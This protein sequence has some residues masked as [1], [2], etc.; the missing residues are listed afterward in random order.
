MVMTVTLNPSARWS[1]GQPVT[2]DDVVYSYTVAM[3]NAT[4]HVS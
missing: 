4:A 2:A 3:N 1:D